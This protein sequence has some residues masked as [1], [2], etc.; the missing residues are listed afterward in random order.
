MQ[1]D[2]LKLCTAYLE[3]TQPTESESKQTENQNKT[4]K[5]NGTMRGVCTHTIVMWRRLPV[6]WPNI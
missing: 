5:F 1:F 3:H 4:L 6:F 2:K